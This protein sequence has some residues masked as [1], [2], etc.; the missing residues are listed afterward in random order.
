MG[1]PPLCGLAHEVTPK[2]HSFRWDVGSAQAM[3]FHNIR[4]FLILVSLTVASGVVAFTIR[5]HAV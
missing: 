4:H 3:V 5:V 1:L 2:K